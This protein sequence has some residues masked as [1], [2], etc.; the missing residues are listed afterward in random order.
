MEAYDR[1]LWHAGLRALDRRE[2]S[3]VAA[4]ELDA[5]ANGLGKAVDEVVADLAAMGE[6]FGMSDGI[7]REL[8]YAVSEIT[9]LLRH[10]AGTVSSPEASRTALRGAWQVDRAWRSALAGEAPVPDR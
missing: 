9:A 1:I 8:A 4:C 2:P 3:V 5:R 7:P 10:F 6:A